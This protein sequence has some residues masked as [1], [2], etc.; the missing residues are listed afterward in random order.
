VEA[1][2]VGITDA[3]R[4]LTRRGYEKLRRAAQGLRVLVP[5][6]DLIMTSPLRRARETAEAVRLVHSGRV[7]ILASDELAPGTPAR[8]TVRALA[9]QQKAHA[10][11]C[12]GH[13]PGLSRLAYYLLT[14]QAQSRLRLKKAGACMLEFPRRIAPGQASLVWSIPPRVL[15]NLAK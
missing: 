4:A 12:V 10:L 8:D 1:A 9:A 15:R 5:N 13:E 14:G 2:A 6:I 7:T 3:D 11:L